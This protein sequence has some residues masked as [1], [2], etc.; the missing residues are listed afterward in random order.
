MLRGR[1]AGDP[2]KGARSSRAACLTWLAL[3][4]LTTDCTSLQVTTIYLPEFFSLVGAGPL[5]GGSL[6]NLADYSFA[7]LFSVAAI[8]VV[9]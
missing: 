4:H 2:R 7:A 6:P 5:L 9:I 8:V 1:G 3:P